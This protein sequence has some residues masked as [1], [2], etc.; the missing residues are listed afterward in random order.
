[1]D[2]FRQFIK[3][4][5]LVRERTVGVI[6]LGEKMAKVIDDHLGYKRT[7]MKTSPQRMFL[8]NLE[9]ERS[10]GNSTMYAR[11]TKGSDEEDGERE[12]DDDSDSLYE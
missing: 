3:K 5:E 12:D 1:M 7:M 8:H 6:R 11:D 4:L 2:A 10:G 9:R